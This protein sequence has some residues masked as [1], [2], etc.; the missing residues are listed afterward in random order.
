MQSARQ[1]VERL[2]GAM[3]TAAVSRDFTAFD[4]RSDELATLTMAHIVPAEP[5]NWRA[6]GLHLTKCEQRIADC[7][8][9]SPG[10]LYSRAA[11]MNAL[12]FDRPNEEPGDKI[13]DIFICKLRKKFKDTKYSIRGIWGKGYEGI[14]TEPNIAATWA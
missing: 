2:I 7:I 3:K 12:Y 9:T 10:R 5:I 14:I 11:L 8:F 13:V 6:E 1:E 4:A